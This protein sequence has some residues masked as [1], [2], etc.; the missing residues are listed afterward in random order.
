MID[1]LFNNF[2]KSTVLVIGDVMID[3]YLVGKVSR[4]SPEAPVPIMDV[5]HREYRLG[6]AANVALNLKELKASPILCSVIGNDDKAHIFNDLMKQYELNSL[7][8]V[9]SSER[10]TT[11]KYRVIG[12]KAQMLRIDDEDKC[13]LSEEEREIFLRKINQI[14]DHQP[15]DAIIFEDMDRFNSNNIFERLHEVN[16]L[17][18]IQRSIA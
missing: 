4:I 1:A 6:G 17:V 9:P 12:N 18:N 8:I 3:C 15:I 5:Q 7:G 2:R 13:I 11:I 16:R 14:I 10:K